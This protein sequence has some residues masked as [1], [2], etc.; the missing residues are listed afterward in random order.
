MNVVK[1]VED[2]LLLAENKNE[3]IKLINE[4]EPIEREIFIMKYF[5]GLKTEDISVRLGMT[6]TSIDNRI[7]RGKKKLNQKASNLRIGENGI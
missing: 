6:K 2:V 4:L 1:S 5:L 7:Y 3:L